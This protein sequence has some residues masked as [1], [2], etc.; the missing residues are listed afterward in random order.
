MKTRTCSIAI[1]AAILTAQGTSYAA[2]GGDGASDPPLPNDQIGQ[3]ISQDFHTIE[4]NWYKK[5]YSELTAEHA[6]KTLV[7]KETFTALGQK[8]PKA[9]PSGPQSCTLPPYLFVRHDRLDTFEFRNQP[10]SS[11]KGASISGT[12]DE[13][14]SSQ[15]LT[16]NGRVEYLMFGYDAACGASQNTSK[17]PTGHADVAAYGF[18][19]AP[20]ADLQ[21]T[22]DHPMKKTDVNN[23]QAG[24]DNQINILGGPLF[25]DQYLVFTPYFQTDFNGVAQITGATA[26]WEPVSVDAHLGGYIP[27][28]DPNPYVGWFWQ[29]QLEFDEKHVTTVGETNLTKGNYEWL[30]GTVQ[31]HFDF[32]PSSPSADVSSESLLTDKLYMNLTLKSFLNAANDRSATWFESELGYNLSSDGKTSISVKYDIGTDKDSLITSKKYLLA[33]NFKN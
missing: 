17:Q 4:N 29:L 6:N 23:L 19:I 25:D 15:T 9:A 2:S 12:D 30:G 22:I 32:F 21:G 10:L 5:L 16:V 33:L 1:A 11:A 14:A 27:A 3:R 26:S 20:F 24:F 8:P 31:A 13:R 18:A 7:D 28:R